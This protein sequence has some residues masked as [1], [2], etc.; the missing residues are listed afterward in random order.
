MTSSVVA[1]VLISVLGTSATAQ[2]SP[3]FRTSVEVT[4]LDVSV[5]D[6]DGRPITNLGADAFVVRIDGKLRRV[7]SAEW[8]SLVSQ[9]KT[10]PAVVVP[11]GF[12][13]NENTTDGRIIVIA[14]DQ[15]HIRTSSAQAILVAAGGFIDRLSPS[16]RVAVVGFGMG[17]PA[18]ALTSDR[19]RIKMTLAQMTGEKQNDLM[20]GEYNIAPSEAIAIHEGNLGMIGA[21]TDRECP[22]GVLPTAAPTAQQAAAMA[23]L[24]CRA[25]IEEEAGKLAT[26]VAIGTD[27]TLRALR[28]LLERLGTIDAPKTLVLIS[29]GFI[30][31]DTE[32]LVN[33]LGTMAA[34]ARTSLYTLQLDDETFFSVETKR[35]PMAPVADARERRASLELLAAA[36]RGT[37]FTTFGSGDRFFSQLEAE[38]S[39]YYLLGVES[40][41]R[42]RDGRA[43]PVRIV[44]P[45][46]GAIVRSRRQMITPADTIRSPRQAVAASLKSPLLL[47]A[48]PLRVATF[49]LQGPERGKV[50][51]LIHAE[52]GK[53]Y[54]D[55]KA[56]ST[57]YTI[58]DQTGR[59]VEGWTLDSQLAPMTNGLPSALQFV[60]G[61]SLTPGEYTLRLVVAEGDKV[62][63]VE[64]PIHAWLSHSGAYT[65]SELMVG[66]PLEAQERLR[67]TVAYTVGAGG[68]HGYFEAYGPQAGAVTARYE[69]AADLKSPA[70]VSSEV[71]GRIFGDDRTIFSFVMPV[72]RLPPGAYVLRARVSCSGP[73]A[74]RADQSFEIA[75]PLLTRS[76]EPAGSPLAGGALLL[77]VDEQAFA[78]PF[79][80]DEAL[81]PEALKPFRDRLAAKRQ[82]G[83]RSRPHVL[84][85]R[86]L[87]K[88]R[89]EP[90]AGDQAGG[91]QHGGDGVPCGDVRRVRARPRRRRPRGRRRWPTA[92]IFHRFTTGWR[93]RWSDRAGWRRRARFSK[94]RLANG[95]RIRDSPGRLPRCMRPREKD[96][97]RSPPSIGISRRGPTIAKPFSMAS[98]GFIGLTRPGGSC[99]A[100]PRI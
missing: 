88:S 45:Q 32:P 7:V 92:A 24:R 5:V 23:K 82:G 46:R 56:V 37:L 70:L 4:S 44:V 72:N 43:H 62:G 18:T 96:R 30:L 26:D 90:Q 53:D 13:T 87:S 59:I 34:A 73:A 29:E 95:R 94:K 36:A 39:G 14:V 78:R 93:S 42:D 64:H 54:S 63:S 61:A 55:A 69:I 57:G 40:D 48:L 12:S 84:E 68:L 2:E 100:R 28:D 20:I 33:E 74:D 97:K 15:P 49:S 65:L 17:G 16:D 85:S 98:N 51:L 19:E 1:V 31:G 83:V 76:A 52:V 79:R 41:P 75:A 66:G 10:H 80:R 25:Q 22:I 9:S 99:A 67:P 71:P 11:D 21:V 3:R 58:A 8:I 35:R 77:P 91:G 27:A 6:G 38:I 60:A 50:Q 86:R 81:T 89:S 47:S